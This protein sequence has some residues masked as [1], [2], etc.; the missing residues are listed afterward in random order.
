MWFNF[1]FSD[2][3]NFCIFAGEC[4]YSEMCMWG[5]LRLGPVKCTSTK[6]VITVSRCD[7]PSIMWIPSHCAF[8]LGVSISLVL[9]SKLNLETATSMFIKLMY[10][11]DATPCCFPEATCWSSEHSGYLCGFQDTFFILDASH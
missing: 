4:I 8:K 2:D 11:L 3:A 9:V 10:M 5:S 7:P 1:E 6:V